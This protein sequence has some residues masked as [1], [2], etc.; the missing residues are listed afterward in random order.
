MGHEEVF[1]H[2]ICSPAVTFSS[3]QNAA[4]TPVKRKYKVSVEMFVGSLILNFCS[5]L[6][7]VTVYRTLLTMGLLLWPNQ[8]SRVAKL[9]SH[10]HL[11]SSRR[12]DQMFG[13]S[14]R[15]R[16]WLL[17]SPSAMVSPLDRLLL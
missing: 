5:S 7:N 2:G 17:I 12:G 15:D 14:S 6:F 1:P 10:Y 11:P 4:L 3:V 16:H 8:S 9:V 13:V